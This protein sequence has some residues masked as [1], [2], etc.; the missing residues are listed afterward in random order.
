MKSESITKP[1][2]IF[3]GGSTHRMDT[4]KGLPWWTPLSGVSYWILRSCLRCVGDPTCHEDC[5]ESTTV[6]LQLYLEGSE[7]GVMRGFGG[8]MALDVSHDSTTDFQCLERVTKCHWTVAYVP[9]HGVCSN[10]QAWWL[11]LHIHVVCL[12][13][14]LHYR[15]TIWGLFFLLFFVFLLSYLSAFLTSLFLLLHSYPAP[16]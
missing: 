12:F 15:H 1:Y 7:H 9:Y 10:S 3:P 16:F 4:N 13:E 8:R 11:M 5:E 14:R 2:G 6:C